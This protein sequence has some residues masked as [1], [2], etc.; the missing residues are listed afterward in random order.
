MS[1]ESRGDCIAMDIVCGKDSLLLTPR[2]HK[3][4]LSIIDFVTRYKIA[5]PLSDPFA[6]VVIS[7]FIENYIT[8]YG[9]PR[10]ILFDQGRNFERSEVIY[11]CSVFRICKI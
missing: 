10:R 7:A 8:V 3:Y 1:V 2:K 6:A 5:V 11:F 9:T 4:I